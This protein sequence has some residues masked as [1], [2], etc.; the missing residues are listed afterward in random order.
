MKQLIIN[1][2]KVGNKDLL[3]AKNIDDAMNIL[4][5]RRSSFGVSTKLKQK[6]DSTIVESVVGI[7]GSGL[8]KLI[9]AFHTL[10]SG[11]L[12]EAKEIAEQLNKEFIECSEVYR[13]L[14]FIADQEEDYESAIKYIDRAIECDKENTFAW[15]HKGRLLLDVYEKTDDA[16]ECFNKCVE[17]DDFM[18]QA[19]YDLGLIEINHYKSLLSMHT[20]KELNED[21]MLNE[22]LY[23]IHTR[24][25]NNFQ[26][27]GA[28]NRFFLDVYP[29]IAEL[30]LLN[31]DF[32]DCIQFINNS[33]NFMKY[34]GLYNASNEKIIAKMK[35]QFEEAHL[36]LEIEKSMN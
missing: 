11:N 33:F 18:Y 28:I 23:E 13:L 17:I 6:D 4:K 3:G 19:Y 8:I 15:L 35:K 34:Y 32:K 1:E 24:A 12:K 29:N 31:N 14:S 2:Y 5:R 30:H 20:K 22:E 27:A 10:Q 36:C 21:L 16:K 7:D 25:F 9:T 26:N